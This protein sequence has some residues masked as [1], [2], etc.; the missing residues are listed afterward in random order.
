MAD[1]VGDLPRPWPVDLGFA[2]LD[3][4]VTAPDERVVSSAARVIARGVPPS[5][6]NH[7][8]STGP[9]PEDTSPWRRELA[10]TLTFRREMYE[11]LR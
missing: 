8:P 4:L 10:A 1:T 6:L 2:L 7:S 9:L 11:E 3:W 5:C